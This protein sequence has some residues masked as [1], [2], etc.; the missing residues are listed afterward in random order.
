MVLLGKSNSLGTGG[1]VS[2]GPRRLVL[3][4]VNNYC[5]EFQMGLWHDLKKGMELQCDL[6][7]K[8]LGKCYELAHLPGA[9]TQRLQLQQDAALQLLQWL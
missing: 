6:H 9:F 8:L 1:C 3:L 7:D 5:L 4:D 2:N